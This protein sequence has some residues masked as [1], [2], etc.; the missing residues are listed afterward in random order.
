MTVAYRIASPSTDGDEWFS[1]AGTAPPTM[2]RGT[3]KFLVCAFMA[4]FAATSTLST[5]TLAD[6]VALN[7]AMTQSG[8]LSAIPAA[9]PARALA[10]SAVPGILQ[11]L[12]G[13]SGLNWGEI[14][15]AVGI[16]RRTVHNWLTGAHVAGVHLARL[17][18]LSRVVDTVATGSVE[19][20]RTALLQPSANGR[21]I[22]DDLELAA[23][24]AR[25]PLSSVSVGDLV[26]PVDET[27]SVS[28]QRLRRGSSLKGGSLPRRRPDKS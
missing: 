26:A 10:N 18:E 2:V 5:I 8:T 25:R 27:A 3:S 11:R 20:T 23:R 28:P 7:T 16:S 6:A 22:L 12:R 14:A 15:R 1:H 19:D 9:Q 13:Q 17:L 21:S 24:P 4:G